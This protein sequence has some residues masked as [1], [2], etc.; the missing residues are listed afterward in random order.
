ML[1]DPSLWLFAFAWFLA[2]FVNGISGMGCALVALPIVA[3]SMNPATL[4]PAT[5]AC[6]IISS[7]AT[8]CFFWRYTRWRA[9]KALLIGALPGAAAGLG[10][11][12]ILPSSVLQLVAGFTILLFVIWQLY[13]PKSKGHGDTVP[14]GLTAGFF[15]GFVNTS[16]TFGNPPV[17]IYSIHAGWGHLE[18]LGTMNVYT[19]LVSIISATAHAS[20]GLYTMDVLQHALFGCPAS[21]F[22][23]VVAFPL[24]KYISQ[25]VFHRILLLVLAAAGIVCV[26]RGGALLM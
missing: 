19:C 18:T 8:A 14:A 10:V 26:F 13:H 24:T 1:D 3:G 6:V 21:V 5:T 12:L 9:L 25:I 20:A 4:V 11:L 2:G 23:M 22:G 15:A 17:A 16:I 7:A